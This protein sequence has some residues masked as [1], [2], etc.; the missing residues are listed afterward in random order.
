MGN[1]STASALFECREKPLKSMGFNGMDWAFCAIKDDD[2]YYIYYVK[3]YCD[4]CRKIYRMRSLDGKTNWTDDPDSP[5]LG[6]KNETAYDRGTTCP[7]VWKENRHYHMIFSGLSRDNKWR[8]FYAKSEDGVSW[9]VQ[10]NDRPII[11]TGGLCKWDQKHAEPTG[12]IKVKDKYYCWYNNIN[13]DTVASR[14]MGLATSTNLLDWE[15]DTKNPIF[16]DGRFCPSPIKYCDSK[17]GDK[18][19]LFVCHFVNETYHSEI[20]LYRCDNPEFY[21]DDPSLTLPLVIKSWVA[22][23]WWEA[24]VLDPVYVLTDNIYRDTFSASKKQLWMYYGA[25]NYAYEGGTRGMGLC[26]AKSLGFVQ[27]ANF[28]SRSS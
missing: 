2:C 15:K 20:E 12:I 16:K 23:S 10:N 9:S 7:T 3:P 25:N 4:P 14:Q 19:Y 26:I 13:C 18:Y 1:T 6:G 28:R 22:G 21:P 8:A 24:N 5:V 11:D 27:G 17:Y